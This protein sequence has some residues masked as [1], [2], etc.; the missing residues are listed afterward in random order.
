[1]KREK[2]DLKANKNLEK[3]SFLNL[4]WTG[5]SWGTESRK[6]GVSLLPGNSFSQNTHMPAGL[7]EKG[8]V[9]R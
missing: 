2:N 7:R 4:L 3:T 6:D 1:M 8:N 5:F 9:D